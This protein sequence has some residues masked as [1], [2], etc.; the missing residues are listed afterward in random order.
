MAITNGF[1]SVF[2]N[3]KN[4]II[5]WA[6][7][8]RNIEDSIK[9]LSMVFQKELIDDIKFFQASVSRENFEIV[10]DFLKS[11]WSSR[12][13]ETMNSL[14][15]HWDKYWLSEYHVGWY[16]GYARGLPSTNNCLES[17]NDSIKEEATLRDRLPL[18][19][20]VIRM[21]RLLSDWSS[22]HDPSF[23]TAKIVISI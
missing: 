5:C 13:V 21:N 11:K 12:N 6:D 7:R 19:Q 1:K 4:R 22:D 16:E 9:S 23:N 15:E 10:N 18:R 2:T 3:L 8:R 20:F 14:F 17:T